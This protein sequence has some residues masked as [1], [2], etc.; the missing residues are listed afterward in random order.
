[1]SS[2]GDGANGL[3]STRERAPFWHSL[4]RMLAMAVYSVDGAVAMVGVE[5]GLC[6]RLS[7]E[8]LFSPRF[9]P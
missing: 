2:C 9:L 5:W 3:I 7:A 8:H 6:S 4:G 1:M